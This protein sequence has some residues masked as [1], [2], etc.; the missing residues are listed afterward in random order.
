MMV[1]LKKQG[2]CIIIF[3]QYLKSILIK[4]NILRRAD[5]NYVLV[6]H[7]EISFPLYFHFIIAGFCEVNSVSYFRSEFYHCRV[8]MSQ[9]SSY[10]A[11]AFKRRNDDFAYLSLNYRLYKIKA[12]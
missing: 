1:L 3:R 5:G 2:K 12:V 6:S 4:S 10:C 8:C 7:P 11:F 9:N